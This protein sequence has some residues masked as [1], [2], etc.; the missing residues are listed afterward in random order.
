[1]NKQDVIDIMNRADRMKNPIRQYPNKTMVSLFFEQSRLIDSYNAAAR[2]LGMKVHNM[3]ATAESLEDHVKL[4]NYYGDILVLRHPDED[5]QHRA[6]MVSDIPVLPAGKFENPTQALVDLYTLSRELE[7]RGITLDSET[8][9]TLHISFLGY[10]RAVQPFVNLLKHFPN[11]E[12]HYVSRSDVDPDLIPLTDVF[13]VSRK[14]DEDA[15]CIDR[16]FLSKTKHTAI[17][18]HHLPRTD[19]LL[20]E[21]DKNPRCVYFEQQENG[22]YMRMATIDLIFSRDCPTVREC[23]WIGFSYIKTRLSMF[24]LWPV[25]STG[26]CRCV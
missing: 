15:Y 2:R 1:M 5:Y 17:V 9:Q 19:E 21:V 11:I 12:L 4:S 14:Q 23:F 18:M 16:T 10:N 6:E 26:V 20:P 24:S 25:V 13:Y 7:F 8:R 3:I 22:I